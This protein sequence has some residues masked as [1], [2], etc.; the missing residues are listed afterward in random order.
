VAEA[1]AWAVPELGLRLHFPERGIHAAVRPAFVVDPR[2]GEIDY[3]TAEGRRVLERAFLDLQTR[4]EDAEA[5]LALLGIGLHAVQDS[6]KHRGFTPAQGHIGARPDPD[7]LGERPELAMESAVVTLNALRYARRLAAGSS[8][9]PPA[10]WKEA[11]RPL[12]TGG[13]GGSEGRWTEFVRS[14][15]GDP[16]PGRSALMER[17]RS[18]PGAEAF[19]RALDRAR[20]VLR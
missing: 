7:A 20:E 18:G 5:T 12:L 8:P 15:F 6:I 13:D 19:D 17:W 9:R 14:R 3:G 16:Y 2:S 11:F 10:S 1:T 4:D